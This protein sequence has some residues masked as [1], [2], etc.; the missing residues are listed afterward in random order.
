L[1]I[2]FK[3][4]SEGILTIEIRNLAGQAVYTEKLTNDGSSHADINIQNLR[5][6]MY[7]L[8]VSDEKQIIG[9]R[10]FIKTN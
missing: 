5:P 3:D 10:K 1:R 6:G 8:R 2:D 4:S 9:D 7:I